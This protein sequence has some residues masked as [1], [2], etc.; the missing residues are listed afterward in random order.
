MKLYYEIVD[1][2]RPNGKIDLYSPV[3]ARSVKQKKEVFYG[4]RYM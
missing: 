4:V 1:F 3:F 2:V